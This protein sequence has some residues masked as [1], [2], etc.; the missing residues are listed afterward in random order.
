MRWN[1]VPQMLYMFQAVPPPI[2]RSTKNC[3]YSFRYCQPVLLLAASV[4]EMERSSTDAL[5]VSGGSSAYHQEHKKL[6]IQLQ[7]LSTSIAASVD[8]MERSSTDALHVSGGSSAYHQEHKNCTYS[9]KY[10][11]PILLLTASVDEMERQMLYMFQAVPPPII[12]STKNCTYSFRY[13][14]STNIA[15]SC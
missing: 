7:V 1:A 5:H 8:E 10:C 9:F 11:Q 15:A 14:L 3:A 13:C 2:I 12:R 4:D 6:Y